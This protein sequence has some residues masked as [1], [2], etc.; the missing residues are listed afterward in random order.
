MCGV[1]LALCGNPRR[2]CA[3]DCLGSSSSCHRD[4]IEVNGAVFVYLADVSIDTTKVEQ[5]KAFSDWW[6]GMGWDARQHLPS[7]EGTVATLDLVSSRP[8]LMLEHHLTLKNMQSRLGWSVAYSQPWSLMEEE[9]MDN[10]K[11]WILEPGNGPSFAVRQVVLEPDSLFPEPD[12]LLAPL[13][14]G[15]AFRFGGFWEGKARLG[16]HPRVGVS[17]DM[18]RPKGWVL[19]Q[20]GPT[21]G[22]WQ[23]TLASDTYGLESARGMGDGGLRREEPLTWANDNSGCALQRSAGCLRFG[24]PGGIGESTSLSPCPPRADDG[25]FRRTFEHGSRSR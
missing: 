7:A 4:S 18:W 17:F 25:A 6:I 5:H 1:V 14:I 20:P 2:T 23:T 13:S 21:V 9:V 8:Q 24:C 19:H 12:T 22:S 10:A 16:W 11:G 3:A 15:H